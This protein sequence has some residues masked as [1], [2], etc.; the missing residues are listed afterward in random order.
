MSSVLPP[1]RNKVEGRI[2]P[3]SLVFATYALDGLKPLALQVKA[4]E[5]H[6]WKDS[7]TWSKASEGTG[8]LSL[9]QAFTSPANGQATD[10]SLVPALPFSLCSLEP[11]TYLPASHSL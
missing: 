4:L 9:L 10:T 1:G 5:H 8:A 3:S 7:E 2:W 11:N 6:G